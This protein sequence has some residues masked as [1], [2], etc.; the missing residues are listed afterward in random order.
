MGALSNQ[1]KGRRAHWSQN[2]ADQLVLRRYGLRSAALELSHC[3]MMH[4]KADLVVVP[5][6]DRLLPAFQLGSGLW[7]SSDVE[8]G[9]LEYPMK[10]V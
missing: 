1:S 2:K 4:F 5:F 8:S 9:G 3:L 7:F 10:C 6:P